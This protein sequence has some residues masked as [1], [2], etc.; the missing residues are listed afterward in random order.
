MQN[1]QEE[2][3]N[4]EKILWFYPA[5]IQNNF[6]INSLL[7]ESLDF[8]NIHEDSN[9]PDPF[10]YFIGFCDNHQ[11]K[12]KVHTPVK[13]IK[14]VS[15]IDFFRKNKNKGTSSYSPYLK[16]S[17]TPTQNN[18]EIQNFIKDK[19]ELYDAIKDTNFFFKE[20]KKFT[21]EINK[22]IWQKK[23]HSIRRNY[24]NK[25]KIEITQSDIFVEEL[26]FED[27]Q[28]KKKENS[29]LEKKIYLTFQK[30]FRKFSFQHKSDIYLNQLSVSSI[31]SH[32]WRNEG[33]K[34][35]ILRMTPEFSDE[36]YSFSKG[37]NIYK[38]KL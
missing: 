38:P 10:F 36:K 9:F 4:N 2:N 21:T 29:L 34:Q 35:R 20:N 37:Y 31:V 18:S 6:Q 28:K 8:E 30:D 26:D 15:F 1:F 33:S 27:S 16:Q 22:T 19:S 7:L 12:N 11:N 17:N 32:R 13:T 3:Q 5:K 14:S 23:Y 25:H 24:Q